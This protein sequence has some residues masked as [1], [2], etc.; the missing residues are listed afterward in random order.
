IQHTYSVVAYDIG[1]PEVDTTYINNTLITKSMED[2]GN[3]SKIGPYQYLENSKGTTIYDD[4]FATTIPGHKP[5]TDKIL[6]TIKVVPNPYIVESGLNETEY[7]S[8]IRFTNLPIKCKIEIYTV[9]GELVYSISHYSETDGN[10]FW[11]LRSINNQE[12]SPG[13][14]LYS[15]SNS[16]KYYHV[17]K[18]AIIR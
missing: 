4:N 9:S 15:V 3:W 1:V 16:D 8:R 13:L 6:H 5:N 11:D 10:E 2:P 14:Y 7:M 17:V 18:F 12:A